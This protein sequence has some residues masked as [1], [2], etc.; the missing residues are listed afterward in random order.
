[1]NYRIDSSMASMELYKSFI[2]TTTGGIPAIAN[3]KL[4]IPDWTPRLDTSERLSQDGAAVVSDRRT[5]PRTLI[6]NF[7]I[8]TDQGSDAT[9]RNAMNNLVSF[10]KPSEGPFYLVDTDNSMRTQIELQGFSINKTM[11]T[12]F[13]VLDNNEA[14]FLMVNTYWEDYTETYQ[15]S[16]TG[17]LT[18]GGSM[19]VNNT[20]SFDVYPFIEIEA[21]D[22]I[23]EF[24]FENSTLGGGFRIE[25]LNFL[26]GSVFEIDCR[27]GTIYLDNIESS[28]SLASGGFLWL[29]AGNN[30]LTYTSNDGEVGVTIAYRRRYAY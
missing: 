23:S 7:D 5:G 8:V 29:L 20:G 13:T 27:N 21:L 10:F 9:A 22:D 17:G 16:G 15:S 11:E 12:Q 24:T 19:V 25:N 3:W 2:Q 6:F 4:Q 14:N 18:N 28:A 1:M 26:V 30:T